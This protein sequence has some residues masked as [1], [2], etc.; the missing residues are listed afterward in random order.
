MDFSAEAVELV[1][2]EESEESEPE[3]APFDRD[4]LLEETLDMLIMSE[5]AV[6]MLEAQ[7]LQQETAA[8]EAEQEAWIAVAEL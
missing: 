2:E 8:Y 3:P 6:T 5:Q 4:W 7:L 1:V